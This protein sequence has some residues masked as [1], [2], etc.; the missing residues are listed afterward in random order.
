[1]KKYFQLFF[2]VAL[3]LIIFVGIYQ[4]RYNDIFSILP[5]FGVLLI[6]LP[7]VLKSFISN[8]KNNQIDFLCPLLGKCLIVASAL[9]FLI[10]IYFKYN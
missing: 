8:Y 6:Q 10:K 9:I 2:F 3:L 5:L 4:D 1:M 7:H